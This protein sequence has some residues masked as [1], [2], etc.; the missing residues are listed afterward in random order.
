M[1][2]SAA[3]PRCAPDKRPRQ[4]PRPCDDVAPDHAEFFDRQ[5]RVHSLVSVNFPAER[6][7]ARRAAAADRQ[8]FGV[9]RRELKVCAFALAMS[10]IINHLLVSPR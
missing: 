3:D 5:S 2:Y 7:L 6:L 9:T 4:P 10:N 1:Q 8:L